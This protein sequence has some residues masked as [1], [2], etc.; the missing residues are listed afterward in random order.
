VG[1]GANGDRTRGKCCE[2]R[3]TA[4]TKDERYRWCS[5]DSLG[6]QLDPSRFARIHRT[7]I[8]NVGAVAEIQP[9]F[10]GDAIVILRDG[11]KLRLSRH[12]RAAIEAAFGLARDSSLGPG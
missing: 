5:R 7:I 4:R 8:V 10:S 11:A 1:P 2:A 12:Y 6:R 3:L 9:W